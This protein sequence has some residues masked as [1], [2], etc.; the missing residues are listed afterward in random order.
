MDPVEA[1]IDVGETVSD[2]PILGKRA[3]AHAIDDAIEPTSGMFHQIDLNVHAR[4]NPFQLRLAIAGKNPPYAG[5]DERKHGHAHVRISTLRDIHIGDIAIKWGA[6]VTPLQVQF[7]LRDL[8]CAIR[9]L[10]RESF[11]GIHGMLGF[12]EFRL[13]GLKAGGCRLFGGERHGLLGLGL[14]DL[15]FGLMIGFL[16]DAHGGTGLIDLLRGDVVLD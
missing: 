9:A 7:R 6:N 2:G 10:R 8:G 12:A 3:M 1:A 4:L 14:Q 11:E 13:G 5:I 16:G 15:C